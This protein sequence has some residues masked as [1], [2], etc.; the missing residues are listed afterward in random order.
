MTVKAKDAAAPAIN[1]SGDTP[2]VPPIGTELK[3][4]DDDSLKTAKKELD[5][6]KGENTTLKTN[7]QK[8]QG[9]VLS[10][11][12]KAFMEAQKQRR[13]QPAAKPAAK[14]VD[15]DAMGRKEY[16]EYIVNSVRGVVQPQIDQVSAGVR[17]DAITRG[18]KEAGEKYDDFNNYGTQMV[19]II[20]RI[21]ADGPSAE[22]IYKIAAYPTPSAAGE[23]EIKETPGEK[24]TSGGVPTAKDLTREQILSEKFD[25]AF[26]EQKKE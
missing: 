17:K 23:P 3:N 25:E 2:L 15:L 18:L 24:P 6:L 11:Q 5:M 16:A 26:G 1:P 22:D 9:L 8:V 19:E 7:L 14:E 4:K 21:Q 20:H 12:Y 13:T 10:P